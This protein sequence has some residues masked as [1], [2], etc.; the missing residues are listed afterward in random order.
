MLVSR[1]ASSIWLFSGFCIGK[2]P[3]LV[4]GAVTSPVYRSLPGP[5]SCDRA[6]EVQLSELKAWPAMKSQR[7]L[8]LRELVRSCVPLKLTV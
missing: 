1:A 4:A 2:M 7:Q 5:V 6:K 8:I 3:R